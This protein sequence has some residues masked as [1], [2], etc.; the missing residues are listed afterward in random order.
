MASRNG[1]SLRETKK[2]LAKHGAIE[3]RESN[4]DTSKKLLIGPPVPEHDQCE[5]PLRDEQGSVQEKDFVANFVTPA[6]ISEGD[7]K[8]SDAH[9]QM[10][11]SYVEQKKANSAELSLQ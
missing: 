9:E 7:E 5:I 4:P 2:K 8:G 10:E 3:I 6:R 11:N 1:Y